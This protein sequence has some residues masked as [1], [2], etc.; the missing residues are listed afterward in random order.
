MEAIN[1]F[2]DALDSPISFF[3]NEPLVYIDKTVFGS[4][5]AGIAVYAI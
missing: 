2:S 3:K 4:G 1:E 5:K